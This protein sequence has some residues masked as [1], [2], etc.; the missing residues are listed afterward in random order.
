[1]ILPYL[2]NMLFT[3]FLTNWS[4]GIFCMCFGLEGGSRVFCKSLPAICHHTANSLSIRHSSLP[5]LAFGD[6]NFQFW[7]YF[8]LVGWCIVHSHAQHSHIISPA[9][10]IQPKLQQGVELMKKKMPRYQNL[11]AIYWPSV[12]HTRQ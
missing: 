10:I 6:L 7:D 4:E 2:T 5:F 9:H 8:R 1:M 12:V 11:Y 3:L